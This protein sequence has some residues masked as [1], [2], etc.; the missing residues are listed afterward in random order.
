MG[1]LVFKMTPNKLLG[2]FLTLILQLPECKPT[3]IFRGS[4]GMCGIVN[5]VHASTRSI[6]MFAISL[7]WKGVATGIPETTI[8]ERK[9]IL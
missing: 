7:A 2:I 8:S 1:P 6:A 5:T 9:E 4:D 3:L